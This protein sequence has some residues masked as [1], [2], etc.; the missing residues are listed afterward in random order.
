MTTI[1]MVAAPGVSLSSEVVCSSGNT[2]I[3]DVNGII[4]AQVIDVDALF[5][6]GFVVNP[7]AVNVVAGASGV[8]GTLQVF[9][10]DGV[11]RVGDG[12]SVVVPS[13]TCASSGCSTP[14]TSALT[15]SP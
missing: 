6:A 7:S 13:P 1:S 3:P 9:P 14:L 11:M 12:R 10:A 15:L 8:V 2:Y 4:N 5:K